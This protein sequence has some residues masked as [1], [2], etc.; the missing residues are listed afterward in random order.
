MFFACR[1]AGERMSTSITAHLN[2]RLDKTRKSVQFWAV[3]GK[4]TEIFI[5]K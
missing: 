4:S 3:L 1:S 2:Y 5:E